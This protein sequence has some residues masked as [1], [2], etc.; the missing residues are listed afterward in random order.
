[1]EDIIKNSIDEWS[2]KAKDIG[3]QLVKADGSFVKDQAKLFSK[4]VL[5][6]NHQNAQKL[7]Q[8]SAYL[9]DGRDINRRP[10]YAIGVAGG[11]FSFI[12][13]DTVSIKL[14]KLLFR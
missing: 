3:N 10:G 11:N 12:K 4:E 8:V 13:S 7:L 5:S 14:K 6:N 2:K 1:M 9:M